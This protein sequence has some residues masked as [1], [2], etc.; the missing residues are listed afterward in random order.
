MV[1]ASDEDVSVQLGRDPQANLEYNVR[2][3]YDLGTP[4]ILPVG[5]GRL[6]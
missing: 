6:G 4:Q 3:T 5:A 2:I 1:W